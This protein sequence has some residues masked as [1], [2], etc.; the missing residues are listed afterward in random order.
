[1]DALLIWERIIQV[2]ALPGLGRTASVH[3]DRPIPRRGTSVG[4]L[5]I[6]VDAP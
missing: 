4:V 2:F 5:D 3:R 6:E 1:M